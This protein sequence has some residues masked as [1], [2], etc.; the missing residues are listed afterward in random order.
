MLFT[1]KI[2]YCIICSEKKRSFEMK[3]QHRRLVFLVGKA[4]AVSS[5]LVADSETPRGSR[6]RGEK[7]VPK[8]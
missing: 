2:P 4:V 1:V 6:E 7:D 5:H 8:H 3:R